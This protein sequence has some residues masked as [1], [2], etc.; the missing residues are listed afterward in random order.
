MYVNVTLRY[1]TYKKE[2]PIVMTDDGE[3]THRRWG[4]LFLSISKISDQQKCESSRLQRW[5]SGFRY[6]FLRMSCT[7]TN[8]PYAFLRFLQIFSKF[9]FLSLFF[10]NTYKIKCSL[11][12]FV[13]YNRN[14]SES[15]STLIETVRRLTDDL[16]ELRDNRYFG[17]M[18][19]SFILIFLLNFSWCSCIILESSW[20]S[21]L[22]WNS[23]QRL[24]LD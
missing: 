15:Y 1:V 11:S 3:G 14:Y 22:S 19:V 24:P 8:H 20:L 23:P 5:L 13:N 16:D 6:I 2:T 12:L 18:L 10:Q 17:G 21:I 7:W 9:L 4:I